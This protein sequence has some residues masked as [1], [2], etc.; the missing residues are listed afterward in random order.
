MRRQPG[1]PALLRVRLRRVGRC[2]HECVGI[3]GPLAQIAQPLD[4]ATERELRTAEALDEVAAPAQ[5]ERLERPQLRVHCAVAAG[6]PLGTDSVA[7]HDSLPFEQELGEGTAIGRVDEQSRGEQLVPEERATERLAERVVLRRVRRRRR[8]DTT[9]S[10]S[11]LPEVERDPVRTRAE[12]DDLAGRRQRVEML[13]PEPP[14]P[15]WQYLCFPQ[16]NRQRESLQRN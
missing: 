3:L 11:V 14:N 15:T 5:A 7:R 1:R 2:E 13:R 8:R 10:R 9:E 16:R 6:N 12:P 4:R